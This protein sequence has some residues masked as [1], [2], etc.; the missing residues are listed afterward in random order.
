MSLIHRNLKFFEAIQEAT[1]ISLEKD[2]SVY[3]IGLGVPDPKGVFGTTSG[4]LEKFGSKRVYDMPISENGVTGVAIGSALVGMRPIITHQRVE[5]ALLS[6]EQIVNQAAKWYHMTAGKKNIPLVIRMI[7]GRG[8][9]QGAQHSQSLESW[10]A[11]IPGL[12]VV[13]P[14][15]PYDAKGLL[16]SAIED[17]NPVIFLEH[18]WLHNTY[19]EVPESYYKVPI[20][21]AKIATEGKDITIVSH[22]YMTVEA[23]KAVKI[24]KK[25]DISCE[26]IDLRS[27]RPLDQET[28]LNSVNKT[29]R[30]LVLDNGWTRY[31]VSAEIIAT[32]VESNSTIL[33]CPPKRIGIEDVP[34]PSTREL[35]KH[36]YPNPVKITQEVFNVL[37]KE[38]P[39]LEEEMNDFPSDIPDQNFSGPF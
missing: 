38:I 32:V 20:G 6:I 2:S 24:L 22:S 15:S 19:G 13:M 29:K 27:L 17:N 35:A 1:S 26:V 14:A 18:R 11:H 21:K 8:W 7:I 25:Y 4:L 30:L 9:G 10:F 3:I 34:I 33:A 12:K 28:I 23:L 5:F 36:C 39:S 31:G 37:G 16:I